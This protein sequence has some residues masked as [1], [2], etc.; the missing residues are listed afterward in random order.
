VGH[1]W[2]E[3]MGDLCGKVPRV[4]AKHFFDGGPAGQG[5]VGSPKPHSPECA[6]SAAS[7]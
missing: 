4:Q 7:P 5:V 3:T 1:Q 6:G 2:L